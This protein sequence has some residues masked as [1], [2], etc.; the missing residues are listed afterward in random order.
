MAR[1]SDLQ[2]A[3]TGSAPVA[4]GPAA[5]AAPPSTVDPATDAP[6]METATAEAIGALVRVSDGAILWNERTTATMTA[7]KPGPQ[8]ESVRRRVAVDAVRFSLV[9]LERRFR[10]YRLRFE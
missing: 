2:L 10:Q 1:I 4:R 6:M 3:L 9:Q 5:A 7:G 8:P